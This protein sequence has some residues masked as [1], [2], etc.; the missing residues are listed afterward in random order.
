M[1]VIETSSAPLSEQSQY[2][3]EDGEK[4]VDGNAGNRTLNVQVVYQ[5]EEKFEWREVVRGLTD[6]Q[7]WI[8][9]FAYLGLIVC[10]YSFSL[11]L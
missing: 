8:T 2:I 6:F 1:E 5:E 11:F 4:S 3:T 9:G 7:A 10:L